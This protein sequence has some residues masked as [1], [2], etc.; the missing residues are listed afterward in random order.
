[1]KSAPTYYVIGSGPAGVAGASALIDAGHR[2]TLLDVGLRLDSNREAL[3]AAMAICEPEDWAADE[4]AA[5]HTPLSANGELASKLA[6]GSDHVYRS[7]PHAIAVD[8]DDLIVRASFAE[9]GL[10]NVWGAAIMPFR[11]EDMSDWPLPASALSDAYAA[12]LKILPVAAVRDDLLSLFPLSATGLHEAK[13][14]QQFE[15]LINTLE[16]NREILSRNN[17]T[18]GAAR[19]AVRFNGKSPADSCN[20]CAHCLHGCPRDLIYSSRQTLAELVSTGKLTHIRDV[21]VDRIVESE[22]GVTIHGA[23]SFGPLQFKGSRVFLAAGIFNSTAILLRSFGWYDRPVHIADAQ[24]FTFPLLQAVGSPNVAHERLHT[25]SQA[26]LDIT[27]DE[28]SPYTVHLQVYGYNDILTDI[29]RHKLG[30]LYEYSPKNALLGRFLLVK[31]YLHS[32]H[33]PRIIATLRQRKEQDLLEL[34]EVLNPDTKGYVSQVM[35]KIRR[36]SLALG[37]C[38]IGALLEISPAGTGFHCGGSFPMSKT[39]KSGQSDT[40]G[41]PFGLQR[42]HVIDGTVFPSVPATTMTQTV[43]ANA[44]RIATEASRADLEIR[45]CVP[46]EM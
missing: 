17:I 12:V 19:L 4:I 1:V 18:F 33:S 3:R 27:D 6:F 7:A 22:D 38:P 8:Y 42:T 21:A 24:H 11:Q 14:S 2:V 15:R 36:L 46:I 23:G 28:I 35:R 34:R 39:P 5:V 13:R 40:L 20:Y 16:R 10:S 45:T 41:R 31:G 37:A 44:F 43:M 26:F 25:L 29:L 32:A 9:G 30:P